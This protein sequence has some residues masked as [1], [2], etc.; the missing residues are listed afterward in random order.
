MME[1]SESNAAQGKKEAGNIIEARLNKPFTISLNAL[2]TAG[3]TWTMKYDSIFL[4]LEDEQFQSS[5]A[6]A[7]GGGGTQ[8][9]TFMPITV[10]KVEVAALYKRPW[11]NKVEDERTFRIM[12]SE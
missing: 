5:Q 2:P 9:F 11:E 7:I 10:G 12:I 6:E 8:I 4:K 3:Y 1:S